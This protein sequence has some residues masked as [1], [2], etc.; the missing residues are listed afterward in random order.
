[1]VRTARRTRGGGGAGPSSGAWRLLLLLA[2]AVAVPTACVLYSTNQAVRNARLAVRQKLVQ[3][4]EP[5]LHEA[6][7]EIA[8][9]WQDRA[10][11]LVKAL[12]EAAP[13]EQFA[14]LVT[15]GVCT[16]AVIYDEA[17]NVT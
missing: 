8:S 9:Y 4:Y 5:P 7:S 12:P 13:P 11:A 6:A 3:A 1:M 2:L 10:D 16:S 17:G 14:E 15:S